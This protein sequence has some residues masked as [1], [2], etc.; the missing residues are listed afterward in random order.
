MTASFRLISRTLRSYLCMRER[1]RVLVTFLK[2][3]QEQDEEDDQIVNDDKFSLPAVMASVACSWMA[4][5]FFAGDLN[6]A[7]KMA[8]SFGSPLL[9]GVLPVV[10][11][12]T[13]RQNTAKTA[14][15]L[16]AAS[17]GLLGAASSGFVGN[18]VWQS[19]GD[20]VALLSL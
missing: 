14:P 3:P 1:N 18:E 4:A 20:L 11:A 16:P 7:L 12:S 2:K 15:M 19:A 9:Y 5:Q 6:E 10:M 13:Q 8:G 17:L